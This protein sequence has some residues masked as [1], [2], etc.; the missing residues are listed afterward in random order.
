MIVKNR[1]EEFLSYLEDTSNLKGKADLLYLPE[2][3]QEVV[4]IVRLCGEKKI[5]LTCSGSRTGTVGGCVPYGGAIL[6][7]EKLSKI[8][9]IDPDRRLV[10]LHPG[11]R[12]DNL[13]SE[14]KKFDL[15]FKSSPT[16]SLASIGGAISTSASGVRGFKYGGIRNYVKKLK[17][18]LIDGT[19]LEI[20]RG[21]TFSCKG[22]F[23]FSIKG[24][25]F[26]FSLPSYRMPPVKHSG[27]YFVREGMDL[28]DLFI[29]SEGTLGIVVEATLEVQKSSQDVFDCIV[30]FKDE[31]R[32]INFVE[33]IKKLKQFDMLDP[34]SLEFFD[35]NSLSFLRAVYPHLKEFKSAV[36]FEQE[37]EE[38]YKDTMELWMKAIEDSG[39][40]L[41]DTWFGDTK[42]ERE[43]IYEFRHKL[44]QLVNEFLKSYNQVKIA[45]DI[46]VGD[47]SFREM[48]RFYKEIGECSK[49]NYINF[50]HIGENHLHFNF[51]P[52]NDSESQKA[53]EC[54][55]EIVKKAL[56]LGG[57]VSAEH[58]IGKLK[59][60]YLEIMYGKFHIKEMVELKR[61][62]DPNFLL[63]RGNLFDVE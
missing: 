60:S 49:V 63:G 37:V 21:K 31:K 29:G 43:K 36:Y 56:S 44:P 6:S 59:K 12:L 19:I 27:G 4:K 20:T 14:L 16:E 15:T 10:T 25:D 26:K 17:V 39:A 58:G 22:S 11:V 55:L 24:R 47:S 30:F 42:K 51:L 62:F 18:I 28:I 2:E 38:N 23:N 33:K 48:Y 35:T 50:G 40:S 9:D 34:S 8:K 52:K 32:A 5:P 1:K 57:T 45:S 13:E 46:A 41:D 61:Y 53:K 3:E 7:L 54:I